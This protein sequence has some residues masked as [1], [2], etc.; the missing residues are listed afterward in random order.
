MDIK[1]G[2][3]FKLTKKVDHGAFGEVYH[4]IN[5]KNNMEVAVKMEL[6]STKHP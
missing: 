5:I 4:G 6:A 3:T 2:N 1:V